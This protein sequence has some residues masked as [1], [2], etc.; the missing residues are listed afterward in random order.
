MSLSVA[1]TSGSNVEVS[2]AA[3]GREF[4]EALVHQVVVAFM[5]GAR[6]GTIAVMCA[7]ESA[8]IDR[9]RPVMLDFARHVIQVGSDACAIPKTPAAAVLAFVL[10]IE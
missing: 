4:N 10:A 8:T 7:G 3:F 1:S 5:A 2:E 6:A 9:L